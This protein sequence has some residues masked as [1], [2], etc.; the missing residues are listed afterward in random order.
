MHTQGAQDHIPPTENILCSFLKL[1]IMQDQDFSE[2]I[3]QR[4]EKFKN[5]RI[6][7]SAI[8]S[9]PECSFGFY[10]QLVQLFYNW[11]K[12]DAAPFAGCFALKML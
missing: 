8:Q 10:E 7:Q 5:K 11:W 3:L 2:Y 12:D 1:F 4:I 6:D 9:K